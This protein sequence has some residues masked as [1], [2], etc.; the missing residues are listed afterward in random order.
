MEKSKLRIRNDDDGITVLIGKYNVQESIQYI[1]TNQIKS[2]QI[3]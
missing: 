2:V 1:Q 3:T